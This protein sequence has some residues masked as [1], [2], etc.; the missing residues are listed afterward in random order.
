MF[1]FRQELARDDNQPL[2]D[3]VR[4]LARVRA[5]NFNDWEGLACNKQVFNFADIVFGFAAGC[6][7]TN[8]RSNLI[9][10]LEQL[11]HLMTR[12]SVGDGA[13]LNNGALTKLLYMAG[14]VWPCWIEPYLK[15][16]DSSFGSR[17]NGSPRSCY[18]NALSN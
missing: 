7:P 16:G 4:N 8:E 12:K 1:A 13:C 18:K 3:G 17:T 15:K 10:L 9:T 2:L 14:I 6:A 11:T 5:G